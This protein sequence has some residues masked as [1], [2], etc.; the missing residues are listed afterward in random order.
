M[1]TSLPEKIECINPNTGRHMQIDA[2]TYALFAKA[3]RHALKGGKLISY[4]EL[5]EGV[6]NYFKKQAISF[7]GSVGWYTVTV[8]KDMQ[9]SGLIEVFTEKGRTMHRLSK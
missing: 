6:R 2:S 3:I 9:A 8:K 7:K 4:T 1:S 5:V